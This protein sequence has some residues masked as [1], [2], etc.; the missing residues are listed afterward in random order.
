MVGVRPG[1]QGKRLGY[2]VNL[3]ALHKFAAD[4]RKSSILE[5][6]DFRLAAI[7]TYI[8]L[9]FTPLLVHENQQER[10]EKIYSVLGLS[11]EGEN[12]DGN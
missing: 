4:G 5:T 11:L 1:H 9:G 7:K 12:K 3:A 8:N 2:L 10:W 6:D